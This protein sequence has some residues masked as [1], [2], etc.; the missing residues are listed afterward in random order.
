MKNKLMSFAIALA[1][2]TSCSKKDDVSSETGTLSVKYGLN[3]GLSLKAATDPGT[4]KMDVLDHQGNAVKQYNPVS[5]AP[6]QIELIAGQY[7]VKAYSEDF[8]VP[9]F[10]TPVYGAEQAVT[11]VADKNEE[12]ILNCVQSNVGIKFFWADEFKAA[13][14]VYSAEVTSTA[15]SL[16]FSKTETRTGYFLAGEVTVKITA[17]TAEK[18]SVFSKTLTVNSRELITVKPM[19]SEAGSGSLSVTINV[20]TDVTERE[21][22]IDIIGGDTGGGDTGGDTGGTTGAVLLVEDFASASVGTV[23]DASGTVWTGN[24]NF[25]TPTTDNKVYQAA[26][27]VKMGS[28]SVGGSMESK[29]L[30][31]SANGGAFTISFNAK[32]WFPEDNSVIIA[33]TGMAE[34]TISFTSTGKA[35]EFVMA[36]ANFTGGQANSTITIKTTTR[37]YNGKTVPQRIFID[38]FKVTETK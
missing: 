33:V 10:E 34:K 1:V 27:S 26:G 9:A 31:L 17:G 13:F 20:N 3:T 2:M 38:D 35:G 25:I 19:Q 24:E 6:D 30:D 36:S 4:F 7:T 11:I 8:S 12:A 15:G 32:G 23:V 22:V 37:E 21:E 16:A 28:S 29:T 14:P 5:E 18:T